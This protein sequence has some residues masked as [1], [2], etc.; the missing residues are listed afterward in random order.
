MDSAEAGER[1]LTSIRF[2]GDAIV[3]EMETILPFLRG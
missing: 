1:A 2:M 3:T